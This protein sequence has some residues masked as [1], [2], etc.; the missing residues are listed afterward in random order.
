[1]QQNILEVRDLCKYYPGVNALNHVSLAFRK[2]EVHALAGENGA[3]KSTLIKMLTGAV[4]PSAGEIIYD[5]QAYTRLDPLQAVHCGIAT[6]YQEFNLI[7][8]LTVAENIFYGKEIMKGPF[9]DKKAM[10]AAVQKELDEMEIVMDPNAY[11]CDLGVAYQQ[12]TEIVKAV[13][14]HSKV[15]ILDEPTAPLTSKETELLFRIVRK[16][17][18]NEVTIIF[19]SHR[20]E[21]I[22]DICDRVTVLR[23]GHW[24]STRDIA[25]VTR[26]SLIAEMVGRPLG[27]SYYERQ[28]PLGEVVMEVKGLCSSKVRDVSFS[29]RKGEI[30]GFG[31]LVGAGR[32][33]VAQA[34]FGADR[35]TAGEIWLH[36]KKVSPKDPITA[37]KLGIGL[38]PEDRKRQGVLLNLPIN[39]NISFSSMEKIMRGPFIRKSL[40]LKAADKYI[41]ELSIKTPGP[42]QLARNL[43]GGNQQKVVLAKILATDCDIIFFDEPTRGIDVG[44]KQEIYALM[45]KL[46]DEQGKTI[47]MISSEMPEL[48]GMSDRILVMHDGSIAGELQKEQFS[49]EAIMNLA[50][51]IMGG[52]SD[53][54]K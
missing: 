40:D 6:V 3:G 48:I 15:L 24:I 45:R 32:T 21:E 25:D 19:I 51:G 46:V 23:D 29:V 52:T 20:M 27:E 36:G 34:I 9:V 39:Q 35:A 10:A 5:G 12:L 38:I 2:G 16:L 17:K 7:P 1:M 28:V 42:F 8:Y 43:S 49:Q 37:L 11:V 22:F 30:L 13:M 33:E 44:A 41:D 4:E 54:K 47:I 26:Q 14:S 31:G 18:E 53:E 50:S